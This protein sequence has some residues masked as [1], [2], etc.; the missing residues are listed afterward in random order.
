MEK[1]FIQIQLALF[2]KNDFQ[3]MPENASLAIKE[4]FGTDITAQVLGVPTNAPSE[5]PRVI[6]NSELVNINLAKNRID[7]FS[8]QENFIQDNFEKLFAITEKLSVA[9][10]RVGFVVTYFREAKMEEFIKLFNQEQEE[11]RT[12]KPKEIS[13]RFNEEGLL[14]NV[15]INNSQMYTTGFVT[16][17]SGVQKNGIIITRDINTRNEDIN[18]NL[19]TK[20]LLNKFVSGAVILARKS[21][22]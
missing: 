20:T 15:K 12:L 6:A 2:F 18:V 5:I 21:L 8:K 19:F 7:F 13:F 17:A 16:D 11:I 9:V 10:G 3:G 14:E 22:I 1:Q 4:Q